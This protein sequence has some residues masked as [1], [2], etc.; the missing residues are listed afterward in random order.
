MKNFQKHAENAGSIL[1]Q[2]R[3]EKV[4]KIE[5]DL[6]EVKTIKGD[7]YNTKRVILATGNEYKKL[8]TP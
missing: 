5:D 1:V 7:T 4:S 8:G 6:F 2:D 3:V